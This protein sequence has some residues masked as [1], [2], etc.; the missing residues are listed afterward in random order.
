MA[1]RWIT[2]LAGLVAVVL[3]A[4]AC[5]G[6]GS[7]DDEKV[8]LS[9][10]VWN[11]DQVP[12]MQKIITAFEKTHPKIDVKVQLTPFDQYWT[13]LQTAAAGGSA[14]DVFWL[15]GPNFQLYASNHM[16]LP[17]SSK[18][19]AA[20]LST[21]VYPKQIVKLYTYQGQLYAVPKDF[22]TIGLWYNKALFDAAGLKYPNA[23]WTWQ[24]VQAAARKLTVKSKRQYGIVSEIN[25][26][27]GY[28][29]TV[30]QAG[31]YIVSPDGKRSG[32]ADPKTIEGIKYWTDFI[33][34]GVSPTYQEMIDTPPVGWFQ[35]GKVAMYYGGDWRAIT[36][37]SDP[38]VKNKV[39]VAPLPK[40]P[41][42]SSAS[43]IHGLGNAVYAK[44]KHPEQALEFAEF[45][46]GKQA[47]Q[48]QA[49]TGAVIPA[50]QGAQGAWVKA[51]PH[52][53][54]QV[55]LDEVADS[56]PYPVSKNTA[57]WNQLETQYLAKAWGG[58]TSVNG[59][60]QAL[61]RAM[62]ADLDKE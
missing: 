26:Q 28:Y 27:E 49:E 42:G 21:P 58:Q 59:A 7:S 8:S 20:G 40:G 47:A 29:N 38:T 43:V 56:V 44:T 62:Q 45:L 57:A 32:Y 5:G 15:N 1:K 54:V 16:L 37:G 50:Y 39:D 3:A 55:F 17:L 33:S 19:K 52:Y 14:P 46:G 48:I 36:L 51:Y 18:L 30:A 60:C 6:G 9:Y 4:S 25:S 53:H 22:D 2:A 23:S 10:A 61:A 31:G 11:K 34:D 24:D 35:S 12:A 41:T 13:K